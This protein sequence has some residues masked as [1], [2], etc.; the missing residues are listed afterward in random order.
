MS[1]TSFNNSDF[2]SEGANFTSGE[3][4]FTNST[5]DGT[6][7]ENIQS[8]VSI[9]T[10]VLYIITLLVLLATFSS[11]YRKRKVNKL[12]SMRPLFGENRPKEMYFQLKAEENPKVNEKLLKTA[13]IRRGAEAVRRLFKLKECEPYMNILYMKGFIGD[14]DH[15]RM[16]I[17]KKLIE[18]E[19]SEVAM[20]AETYKKGW[21]QQ[22]F[23]VCQETTMNEALRRRL[24]AIDSRKEKLAKEW[25]VDE[26]HIEMDK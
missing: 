11:F 3:G 1:D 24:N 19:L 6:N 12:R 17:Q 16:K 10:P 15:E 20:E 25:S 21:A 4:N 26:V 22:L 18:V 14:E 23:P 7:T 2:T 5:T 13:L 9:Y 8:N